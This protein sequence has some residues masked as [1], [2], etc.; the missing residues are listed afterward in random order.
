MLILRLRRR[1]KK[2]IA[3][4]PDTS[5]IGTRLQPRLLIYSK[6]RVAEAE[7]SGDTRLKL[8]K[9]QWG[10]LPKIVKYAISHFTNCEKRKKYSLQKSVHKN[11]QKISL[12]SIG[13]LFSLGTQVA[14]LIEWLVVI[15]Q[16]IDH[17]PRKE[18][19][20]AISGLGV[21][22]LSSYRCCSTL[23]VTS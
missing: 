23:S 21:Q 16:Q 5:A 7:V 11:F 9:I 18:L 19:E 8:E 15:P 3:Y 14:S 20:S 4:P 12:M 13:Q 17:E 2:Y 10:K 6:L 22:R 1:G